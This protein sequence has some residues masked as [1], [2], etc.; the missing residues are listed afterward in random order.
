[1]TKAEMIKE[2]SG[3]ADIS[4]VN[5]A[6]VLNALVGTITDEV[7]KTGRLELVG[8]GVFKKITRAACMRPHPQK[9]GEKVQ[10]LEHQTV[11]FKPCPTFK[12]V[13][14]Q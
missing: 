4:Q 2:I 10:V 12:E 8:L 9:K 14:N 3:R 11:K 7:V 1:M 6:A 13:V 5:V